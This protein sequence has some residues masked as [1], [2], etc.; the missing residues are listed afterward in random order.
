MRPSAVHVR[1]LLNY[2]TE[3]DGRKKETHYPLFERFATLKNIPHV[4][5]ERIFDIDRFEFTLFPDMQ[6]IYKLDL[7][8]GKQP[9]FILLTTSDVPSGLHRVLLGETYRGHEVEFKIMHHFHGT[10][11]LLTGYLQRTQKH[12]RKIFYKRVFDFPIELFYSQRSVISTLFRT[13][14]TMLKKYHF[15]EE[16]TVYGPFPKPL[17]SNVECEFTTIRYIHNFVTFSQDLD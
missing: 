16:E 5:Q 17:S 11:P 13:R 9:S 7:R 10:T 6:M 12:P 2:Q 3:G 8:E 4:D 1:F 14:N 15:R